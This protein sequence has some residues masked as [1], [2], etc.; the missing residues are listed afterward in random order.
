MWKTPEGT[1]KLSGAER[2]IFIIG[3]ISKTDSLFAHGTAD[4]DFTELEAGVLN[5]FPAQDRPWILFL[6]AED[7]LGDGVPPKAF[8]WNDA[9]V[10]ESFERL[11]ALVEISIE[12]PEESDRIFYRQSILDALMERMPD[13]KDLFPDLRSEDMEEWDDCVEWLMDKVLWDRDFELYDAFADSGGKKV[14]A[15]KEFA[16]IDE[17][18]FTEMPAAMTRKTLDR[19]HTFREKLIEELDWRTGN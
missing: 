17:D 4:D 14:K 1:R 6:V 3:L 15:I 7:L 5:Q 11:R 10:W 13:E 8:A 16:G 19:L 12:E 2:R 9:A 18:Y